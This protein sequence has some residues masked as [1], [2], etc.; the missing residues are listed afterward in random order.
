MI[1][2]YIFKQLRTRANGI[3]MVYYKK[4]RF[5]INRINWRHKTLI[6]NCRRKSI[7]NRIRAKTKDKPIT[8]VFFVYSLSMWKYEVLFKLLCQNPLY[9]PVIVPFILPGN[10]EIIS[11]DSRDKIKAYCDSMNF[12]FLDGYDFKTKIYKDIIAQLGPDIVIYTQPY[13]AGPYLWRIDSA[14]K[15]SLFIYTTYGAAVSGGNYFYDTYLT[16]IA[17]RIFTSSEL[18]KKIYNKA[19]KSNK[20]SLVVTGSDIYDLIKKGGNNNSVWLS[21]DKKRIIWAPHHS[22]DDKNSFCSSNFERIYKFMLSMVDKYAKDVEFI[23][24][25]HPLLKSRLYEKWGKE[26]TDNFFMEWNCRTNASIC[27]GEYTE[28]FA[29][30][31]AMIHD[32]GSFAT[33]Y[34]YVNKPVFFI[35]KNGHPG[36]VLDNEYGLACFKQHYTG[37]DE[38]SI[39]NFIL[40]TV[41]NGN[42]YLSSQRSSFINT[43]LL[44]PNNNSAGMNM[45]LEIESIFS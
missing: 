3:G 37:Y 4:L 25:P 30:S 45:F 41:I 42:D 14:K 6:Y 11:L 20:S 12:P 43:Q 2:E 27:T 39:E 24:K 31:D 22:I 1:K 18:E 5:F 36:K 8:I 32:C 44:P 19:L 34:L 7:I 9:A 23:L 21:S 10:D 13:D 16:N 29:T 35:C 40:D 26:Q 15:N 17:I 28:L 33:E 38:I